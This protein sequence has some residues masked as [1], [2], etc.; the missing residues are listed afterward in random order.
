MKTV[1]FIESLPHVRENFIKL[2]SSQLCF[3]NV[4]TVES[5]PEAIE[6]LEEIKADVVVTGRQTK[7]RDL[8]LLVQSLR[9]YPDIKLI[10][11]A[12]R[13]SQV[14]SLLKAF[15][16]KIKFETP[17]DIPL[18]LE[19]LLDEFGINYGGQLRGINIA[20]FLQM[21]E[22]DGQTCM[23]KVLS[24]AKT[25]YLYCTEGELIEAELPPLTGKE[26]A[27]AILGLENPLVTVDYEIPSRER[28]I[29]ESLMS[30]LLESGRLK[31]E[32]KPKHRERRRY[33][34]IPCSLPVE[35]VYKEWSYKAVISNISLSGIFIQ[36]DN[37]FSV[38]I[39]RCQ[40]Y[41]ASK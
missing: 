1:L 11:M 10:V 33:K 16:Y 27:F 6:L 14:A 22:L 3:F 24:G 13:K 37:P 7:D 28:T 40:G 20:S 4:A 5:V 31:D 34:R 18:L 30:L 2:L 26:A 35:F 23:L 32:Q 17:V 8:A 19:T 25:G 41:L 39:S 9:Q 29:H 21:I 38:Q 12:D 36:T 15:E